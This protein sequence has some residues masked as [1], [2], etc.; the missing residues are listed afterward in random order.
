MYD[1]VVLGGGSGG[2]NVASAAAAVGAKV[3]LV[4]KH[5]LGGECT[6][7]ACVPSKALIEAAR[8]AHAI[9]RA[10]EFGLRVAGPEVDF[11]AV[12][13]RVRSVVA[14][15]AGGDSGE[16][17]QAKGIDVYR[18]SPEFE[19]YD[20]VLVDGRRV[21]G[22]RF[23]IA[24][25]SRPAVPPIPGLEE[26]GY[27]DNTTL[28][29][30]EAPPR[31]LAI[32]GGGAV[33]LEFGQAL[34]RLGVE[35]TI[36]EEAPRVLGP[37]DA[38]ASE[39]LRAIL[40]EEGLRIVTDAEIT[41]VVARDG[42]KVLKYRSKADGS[43][44][45]AAC[46]AILVATGRL[47]NVEGLNLK[48]LHIEADPVRGIA[49]DEYLQTRAPNVWAIGDVIGRDRYTHAAEREASVAFQNAVLRLSKKFDDRAIPRSCFTDPEVA[50][51][52]LTESEALD[53]EPG[54]R[55]FRAEMADVDRAR[56]DGDT[57][58]LAKVVATPGGK[59]LGAVV[60]GREASLVVQQ[61]VLAIE[62]DLGLADLAETVQAYPTVAGV[63]RRLANQHAATRLEKG[64]VRTALRWFLGFQPAARESEESR[65]TEP[66][67]EHSASH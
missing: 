48:A 25:G 16:S 24:T 54:A 41:A 2:L 31:S 39:C 55:V 22:H 52:G 62:H 4:E 66:A 35:V 30:L 18:G 7:T 19:A 28:W 37:E 11:A 26:A 27:L 67:A 56:I 15:F 50:S 10:G 9:R 59:V 63:V 57:R 53:R 40:Q 61:F 46:D 58:G 21:N 5:R 17:L 12:M 38:E 13:A 44:S 3:A 33:G 65:A 20:T 45:E 64:F 51:V 49:V 29:D 6:H 14:D 8:V 1:L 34:R 36:L 23:V 43:A 42:R 60:V 47:A 32:V